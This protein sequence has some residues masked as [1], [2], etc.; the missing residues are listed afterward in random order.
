LKTITSGSGFGLACPKT[1]GAKNEKTRANGT[2]ASNERETVEIRFAP[3]DWIGCGEEIVIRGPFISTRLPEVGV[4][5]IAEGSAMHPVVRTFGKLLRLVGIS[6]PEDSAP[7]A[8]LASDPPSWRTA[9]EKIHKP[10]DGPGG[11]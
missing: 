7:K 4:I 11:S 5:F 6:S 8:K 10:N 2:R 1:E 9:A 3:G